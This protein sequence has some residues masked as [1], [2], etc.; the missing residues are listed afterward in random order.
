MKFNYALAGLVA[1]HL[2]ACQSGIDDASHLAELRAQLTEFEQLFS[3]SYDGHQQRFEAYLDYFTDE[4]VLLHPEGHTTHGKAAA[5]E[6]YTTAFAP[7]NVRSL[8]YGAPDILIDGNLAIRRYSGSAE[9]SIEND[10][11][12]HGITNRYVDVLE[13]KNNGEWRIVFHAWYPVPED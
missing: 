10:P 3:T 5:L 4:L 2:A 8:D 12:V 9:F 6:F 13:R 1:M 11:T 7:I